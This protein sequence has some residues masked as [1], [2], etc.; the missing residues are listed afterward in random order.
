MGLHCT[1]WFGGKQLLS[2][3]PVWTCAAE[4]VPPVPKPVASLTWSEGEGVKTG[5]DKVRGETKRCVISYERAAVHSQSANGERALGT[6]MKEKRG[7]ED[8]TYDDDELRVLRVRELEAHGRRI[9]I[10]RLILDLA[11]LCAIRE[12]GR[13]E[14]QDEGTVWRGARACDAEGEV[15][16]LLGGVGDVER[17][18][19]GCWGPQRGEQRKGDKGR[20]DHARGR[21]LCLRLVWI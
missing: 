21:I 13:T 20:V 15:L 17:V 8:G 6:G 3:E 2:D 9:P 4:E 7:S 1:S 5:P 11:D 18:R 10:E 16:A 12:G 14:G 19:P